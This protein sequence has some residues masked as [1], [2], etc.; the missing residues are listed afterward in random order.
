MKTF[1]RSPMNAREFNHAVE[2][3]ESRIAPAV[4]LTVLDLD[5]DGAVDDIRIVGDGLQ[6]IVTIED[7]GANQL[8]I[9]IDADG[10][11]NT[12]GPKDKAPTNF[13]FNGGLT[14]RE[15]DHL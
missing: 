4:L 13:V 14:S 12:T 15:L 10:N 1:S 6:N 9:S 8:T 2:R 5:G 3:L 11:G 7:N